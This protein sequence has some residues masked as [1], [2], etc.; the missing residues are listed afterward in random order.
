M[1]ILYMRVKAVVMFLIMA[2]VACLAGETGARENIGT[3]AVLPPAISSNTDGNAPDISGKR[4][5]ASFAVKPVPAWA[6]EVLT[7]REM[8][9][10][11]GWVIRRVFANRDYVFVI[12]ARSIGRVPL[13]GIALQDHAVAMSLSDGKRHWLFEAA[14]LRGSVCAADAET[15]GW[16]ALSTAAKDRRS[17]N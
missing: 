6:S 8:R 5:A 4:T 17:G 1:R 3:T 14:D 13:H 9:L 12:G 15:M 10:S 11:P 2:E 16:S 7:S